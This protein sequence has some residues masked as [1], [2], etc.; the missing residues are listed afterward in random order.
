MIDVIGRH[1]FSLHLILMLILTKVL[2]IQKCVRLLLVFDFMINIGSVDMGFLYI[3]LDVNLTKV[4][5]IQ[6]CFRLPLVLD[7]MINFDRL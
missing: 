4:F 1:G 7:F 5:G 3:Y 6:N 2:G